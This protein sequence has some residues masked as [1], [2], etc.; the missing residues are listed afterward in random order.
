M[1]ILQDV[2]HTW[3]LWSFSMAQIPSTPGMKFRLFS[4]TFLRSSTLGQVKFRYVVDLPFQER[5]YIAYSSVVNTVAVGQ[6]GVVQYGEKVVHEFKLSDYKS[7]KDVVKRAQS[8]HQRGGEETNTALGINVARYCVSVLSVR[9]TR[10]CTVPT[11][12]CVTVLRKCVLQVSSFQTRRSARCQEGDDCD[13]WRRV[14]W[15]PR[16]PA[17]HWGLWEG[18]HHPL[19]NC[20]ESVRPIFSPGLN[21][22]FFYECSDGC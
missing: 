17:S 14:T 4:S 20:C 7:V 18:R 1:N 16:S 12:N 3:T 13:N 22:L 2:K 5:K 10:K 11:V 8:I 9:A 15:Q 21:G 19:C 6:V